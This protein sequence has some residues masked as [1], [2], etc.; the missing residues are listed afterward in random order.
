MK[1]RFATSFLFLIA[2]ACDGNHPRDAG[3]DAGPPPRDAGHDAGH[4]AGLRDAGHDAAGDDA[5]PPGAWTLVPGLPDGCVVEYTTDASELEG[6]RREPC[7]DREGCEWLVPEWEW[8]IVELRVEGGVADSDPPA[9]FFRRE[10]PLGAWEEWLVLE[11]GTPRIGFRG[12]SRRPE[13]C[14][15][16]YFDADAMRYGLT[17]NQPD[18]EADVLHSWVLGGQWRDAVTVENLG[19]LTDV[20]PPGSDLVAIRVSRGRLAVE[21][22]PSHA[23]VDVPWAGDAQVVGDWMDGGQT[24]VAAVHDDTVFYDVY[25]GHH[26]VRASTAG[27]R[28]RVL[29]DPS[30]A[31]AIRVMTDG[32]DMAWIQAYGRVSSYEF[33]RLELWASPYAER[34]EDLVPRHVADLSFTNPYP[35]AALGSGYVALR[36]LDTS[37]TRAVIGLYRLSD[38]ARAEI[39]ALVATSFRLAAAYITP[40]V[41]A[42]G[43]SVGSSPPRDW[44]VMFLQ[45]DSLTFVAP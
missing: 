4:D 8:G 1:L 25:G 19:R 37:G 23:I 21:S 10:G 27:E 18:T 6:F 28:G 43:S 44:A 30:D 17:I 24:Y 45:L 20:G 40:E 3:T 33:D 2:L 22:A 5:G 31:E 38:G 14:Y 15:T 11:D 42:V 34:A 35:P 7:T 16:A 9:F 36:E 41:L 29:I 13:A 26:H 32:T 39:P 12:A